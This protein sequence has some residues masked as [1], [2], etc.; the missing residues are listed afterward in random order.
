MTNYKN[1]PVLRF[2][3]FKDEWKEKRVGEI[4]TFL[5]SKRVPIS[6][7]ERKTRQ[8]EYPYYGASGIIDYIND[9]IFD[10]EYILLG[11]DGANIVNR[12]TPL[13][14]IVK[15]KIWVNNHAHIISAKGNN[16]FLAESLER[17]RYEKYN[18]GTAQPK[19]NAQV[20]KNILINLPT[21]P[22]QQKIANFLTATDTKIQQLRQKKELLND[23]KKGV[24]QQIFKQDIRFKNDGGGDFE[25]WE[26]VQLKD[27]L[28]E[29]KTR[30]SKNKYDEVFSVAKTKGVINQIEHL[31]RSYAS[32]NISNY[33]VVFPNDIV[34]TKSPTSNFPYGIIK[35]NQLDRTGVVSVLYAV[36]KPKNRYLGFILHNYFLIWQNTYNYLHPLVHKGAKNTMNI[37]NT[38][39]LNGRKMKL[40]TS[41]AEQQKIAN[42]LSSIDERIGKVSEEIGEM[43]RYKKG[44]LQGM[45]V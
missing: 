12:S 45:F 38:I 3:E 42:F 32:S 9:Y 25:D 2:R 19:L 36:L 10:G 34:Y 27:V 13:A 33:K 37:N 18:T 35:Q 29:R 22:E 15:G 20:C 14:F 4:S 8:G 43:E 26:T 40:P 39:F 17:L 41:E 7:S 24:M 44:L 21:K 6:Q 5:D 1:V 30:N 28:S 16:K 23:Y 31:G 11:E